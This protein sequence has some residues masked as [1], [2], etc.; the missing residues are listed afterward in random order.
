MGDEAENP[1]EDD[2]GEANLVD[3]GVG[4]AGVDQAGDGGREGIGLGLWREERGPRFGDD[5][6]RVSG[7]ELATDGGEAAHVADGAEQEADAVEVFLEGARRGQ[8]IFEGT[9]GDEAGE[10]ELAIE[11][12]AGGPGDGEGFALER[13]EGEGGAAQAV[14]DLGLLVG[15]AVLAAEGR[16]SAREGP[17]AT[18]GAGLGG[19]G[20]AATGGFVCGGGQAPVGMAAG[21]A[22]VDGTEEATELIEAV[23]LGPLAAAAR[24]GSGG[25]AAARMVRGGGEG[26]GVGEAEG[27]AKAG[28]AVA[29]G[30]LAAGGTGEGEGGTAP[31]I[32]RIGK[33]GTGMLWAEGTAKAFDAVAGG[34]ILALGAAGGE[35][36][37]AKLMVVGTAEEAGVDAAEAAGG[38][39]GGE[40]VSA[41]GG[42]GSGR[43]RTAGAVVVGIHDVSPSWIGSGPPPTGGTRFTGS[44]REMIAQKF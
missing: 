7:G 4:D 14:A 44:T 25:G 9:Q 15:E 43:R 39:A 3:Q 18:A 16:G 33:A 36:G 12:V 23:V 22:G 20:T 5:E 40:G 1:G 2:A 17:A 34:E 37:A 26:G 27:L 28:E 13:S 41:A 30:P 38:K 10:E 32:G 42:A 29:G 31:G 11:L 35:G 24:G 21:G 6:G 8:E 19:G